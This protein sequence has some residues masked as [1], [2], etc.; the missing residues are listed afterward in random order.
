MSIQYQKHLMNYLRD[1]Q[2]NILNPNKPESFFKQIIPLASKRTPKEKGL[3]DILICFQE[4][5]FVVKHVKLSPLQELFPLDFSEAFVLNFEGTVDKFEKENQALKE[6][7]IENRF[8]YELTNTEKMNMLAFA[9]M[10]SFPF[11]DNILAKM[12][13]HF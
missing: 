9:I 4:K 5:L 11:M 1:N 12:K 8:N 7:D 6:E 10:T 3:Y 2:D 13:V